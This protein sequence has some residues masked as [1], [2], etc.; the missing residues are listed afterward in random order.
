MLQTC[1]LFIGIC[2]VFFNLIADVINMAIDPRTRR[3]R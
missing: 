2:V 3:E 1:F